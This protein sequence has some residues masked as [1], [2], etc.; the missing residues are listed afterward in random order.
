MI[1]AFVGNPRHLIHELRDFGHVG[2]RAADVAM[3]RR[4]SV[5]QRA[6]PKDTRRLLGERLGEPRHQRFRHDLIA[7]VPDRGHTRGH[8]QREDLVARHF[9]RVR[10]VYQVD[11]PCQNLALHYRSDPPGSVAMSQAP[12]P[13]PSPQ[14]GRG[15]T[16]TSFA[17]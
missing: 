10:N 3:K 14:K 1:G 13:R 4:V 11:E 8:E 9:A 7:D 6:A 12:L 16:V 5:D 15:R 2:H 17:M